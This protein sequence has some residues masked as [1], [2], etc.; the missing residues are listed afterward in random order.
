MKAQLV[1][2]DAW[3]ATR[4]RDAL[5]CSRRFL[6]GHIYG[7]VRQSVFEIDLE[8]GKAMHTAFEALDRARLEKPKNR[9][10]W[11]K[12]A[13]RAAWAASAHWPQRESEPGW[14]NKKN[15]R[16]LMAV[17]VWYAEQFDDD[18]LSVVR[19]TNGKP[20]IEV[21]FNAPVCGGAATLVSRPD[22]VVQFEPGE[23]WIRERKSTGRP[24]GPGYDAQWNPD[25]QITIQA[26]LGAGFLA[27][28]KFRFR[29]VIL[30]SVHLYANSVRFSRVFCQ[31]AA[32][33]LTEAKAEIEAEI[34]GLQAK[35]KRTKLDAPPSVNEAVWPK[36]EANCFL[37]H[38]KP[39]C[40]VPS[41]ERPR[42]IDEKYQQRAEPWNPL[43]LR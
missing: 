26:I 12:A 31:R 20:A 1:N 15:R 25:I 4:L 10:Y 43:G 21:A 32:E 9:D 27:D 40:A 3:D 42:I 16:T 34:S 29:G 38:F 35:L 41:S 13:L 39:I 30:E 17:F 14:D 2:P 19:L 8:F 28:K 22:G 7:L 36:R 5:A 23:V 18:L 6:Y 37:C 11:T 33:Q 24:E